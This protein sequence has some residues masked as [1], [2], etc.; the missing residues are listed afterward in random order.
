MKRL[1]RITIPAVCAL[2]LVSCNDWLREDGPMTSSLS[3]FF[4]SDE[5]AIQS[6]NA[7]YAPLMWEYNNTYF[8]E[9]FIGDIASDDALKGGQN[10]SDMAD[11]YDI[12][13]FR[14]ISNNGLL[15]EYYRAQYQGIQRANLCIEQVS[16]MD[17]EIFEDNEIQARVIAEAKFLRAYYYFRL[18]RIFGGVPL[19]KEPIYSSDDWVQQRA[20]LDDIYGFITENLEEA[21]PNLPLKSQYDASDLGRVTKGAAQAMLMK[22][23]LYWGNFK[24]QRVSSTAVDCYGSAKTWGDKFLNEQA[25]EYRLCDDYADNFTLEGENGPESIFEI[26]YM[27]EPTS[28]YGEGNGFT[29][30]TFTTILTR[31]RSTLLENPGWGMNKPTDNLYKE[32]ET[33]DP[34]RDESIRVMQDNEIANESEEIY[35]GCRN[36][37]VKRTLPTADGYVMLTHN[38]RSPINNPVYRLADFYLLYAEV[39]LANNDETGAKTYLEK[40][41]SRARGTSSDLPA[42][43]DYE[44]RDYTQGYAMHRLADT[45]EDLEMAIRHERRVELAMEGHRWFDLCRWGIVKEVMDAYK[46]DETEEARN[47]MSEFIKGKH[48]LFPIP[49]EEVRLSG[50]Q[51]NNGY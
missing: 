13:N 30:G 11:V 9:W 43:P 23:Y 33:G 20:S 32:F 44:I 7:A 24:D 41:R 49:D 26:Q 40:V 35:L 4:T 37:A 18:V 17:P 27:E 39:C 50:L 42:F 45:P 15:L 48:E 36:V 3:E 22:V 1:I 28:D 19:V 16:A 47:A 51:Q 8:C 12:E 6:V 46:A 5:A 29:R 2:V 31:S 38:T 34:R 10:I 21:E 14:T 25:A